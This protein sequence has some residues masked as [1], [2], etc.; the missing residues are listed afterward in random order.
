MSYQSLSL[1][2]IK[3]VFQKLPKIILIFL[4][5]FFFSVV[6]L[7]VGLFKTSQ[8]LESLKK[9]S[10][11]QA[12]NSAR[13]AKYVAGFFQTITLGQIPEI[14]IWKQGLDSIEIISQLNQ[15]MVEFISLSVQNNQLAKIYFERI[16]TNCQ[17]LLENIKV[18]NDKSQ[19]SWFL[20]NR[21]STKLTKIEDYLKSII[22][23]INHFKLGKHQII[24][25]L[26][27]NQ[28]I[29]ATGGFMGS[30]AIVTINQGMLD[31]IQVQD[32]YQPDG[33]FT[34]FIQAPPGV[35][36]YLSSGQGLRL[37]D[38]NWHPDFSMSSQEILRFFALGETQQIEGIIAVNLSVVEDLLNIF[39]GIYLP[40]YDQQINADNLATLARA[41]RDQFFPGSQQKPQFLSNLTKSLT[42]KIT[43]L[44]QEQKKELLMSLMTNINNKNIQFFHT[45]PQIQQILDKYNIAGEIKPASNLFFLV[46]SN[47]GINKANKNINRQ[48]R[49]DLNEY[50]SIIEVNFDN[51]NNPA[52]RGVDRHLGYINYQRLILNPEYKITS[53]YYQD[54]KIENWDETT[55]SNSQGNTFKQIGFLI[56]LE[57]G[58]TGSL[59]IE[60]EHP[61]LTA[62][63]NITILRQS[64]LPETIY[65]ITYPDFTKEILL[66]KDIT[67][68]LRP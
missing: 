10:I 9:F 50:R 67:L 65:Q 24:V 51:K 61:R 63:Q 35:D 62:D 45:N 17:S 47:V 16:Q 19:Q 33:Q 59:L 57:E 46:E 28:E 52:D 7:I 2:I 31:N 53:I 54:K 1:P 21:F 11:S 43:Y 15:D 13:S 20:K 38:A 39:G 34:G 40:D 42:Q 37:P 30:F 23:L 56:T 48:V 29:R 58:K 64:G 12:T 68:K 8:A 36:Q 25:L 3:L 4:S 27:N 5:I 41:D 49:L 22:F 44:S 18:I 60:L 26:Q 55:I 66:E 6:F 14:V 32:I